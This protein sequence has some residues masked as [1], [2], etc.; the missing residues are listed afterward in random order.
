MKICIS[1]NNIIIN[2]MLCNNIYLI[3]LYTKNILL[4]FYTVLILVYNVIQYNNI[5]TNIGFIK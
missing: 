2:I 5:I 4:I 1:I 3:I